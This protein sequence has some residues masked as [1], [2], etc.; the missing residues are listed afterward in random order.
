[1]DVN[2]PNCDAVKVFVRFRPT[3]VVE[4]HEEKTNVR[5]LPF[6]YFDY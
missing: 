6:L 4:N 1:M 2:S 3:T 5:A